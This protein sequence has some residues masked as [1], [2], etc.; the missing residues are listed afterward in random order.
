MFPHIVYGASQNIMKNLPIIKKTP[1]LNDSSQM[2]NDF[3]TKSNTLSDSIFGQIK[4]RYWINLSSP[5]DFHFQKVPIFTRLASHKTQQDMDIYFAEK[6]QDALLL[7]STMNKSIIYQPIPSDSE[8]TTFYNSIQNTLKELPHGGI[9][10]EKLDHKERNYKY[11]L[12]F[13]REKRLSLIPELGKR[14]I[15]QQAQ[16]GNSI[17]RFSNPTKLGNYSIIQ[18]LRA[19]P[20]YVRG[21]SFKYPIAE[22]TVRL[23]FPLG[24][25]CLIP[26]FVVTLVKEKESKTVIMMRMVKSISFNVLEW[27]E[28]FKVFIS[29]LL[30][31]FDS[32]LAFSSIFLNMWKFIWNGIL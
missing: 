15:I 5:L 23:L 16:L 29:S 14:L 3:L 1:I 12:Q 11:T 17:L 24:L 21:D 4:P 13:G 32:L 6:I 28:A 10:I 2:M 18:G 31:L 30:C 27:R 7:F 26:V 9:W 20:H 22:F 8:L 25:S 19:F